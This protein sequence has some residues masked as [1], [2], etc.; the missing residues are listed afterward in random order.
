MSTMRFM[1]LTMAAA[2]MLAAVGS[3]QQPT[4]KRT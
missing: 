1:G 4:F 3:A 2:A